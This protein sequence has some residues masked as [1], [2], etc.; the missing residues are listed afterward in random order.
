MPKQKLV[1]GRR[2]DKKDRADEKKRSSGKASKKRSSRDSSPVK[3]GI[4]EILASGSFPGVIVRGDRGGKAF[5]DIHPKHRVAD[6]GGGVR[7]DG[8]VVPVG[9]AGLRGH[10]KP[11]AAT[12][13]E[14]KY[15]ERIKAIR[16][17]GQRG[18]DLR[19]THS[20]P[21]E[22][23]HGKIRESGDPSFWKDKR[24]LEQ[25]TSCKVD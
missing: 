15:Q 18:Q 20:V 7:K 23:Y 22:L 14:R 16:N 17:N 25:A 2:T 9:K 8:T 1:G 5:D 13:R 11:A 10:L 4:A 19:M 6:T 12:R 3:S 24:N 21:V